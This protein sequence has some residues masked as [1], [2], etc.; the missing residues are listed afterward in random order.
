MYNCTLL[1][2]L[3]H[4]NLTF[5]KIHICHVYYS[6]LHKVTYCHLLGDTYLHAGFL[7]RE[8]STVDWHRNRY[9]GRG[10]RWGQGVY[11][12]RR[13]EFGGQT[14]SVRLQAAVIFAHVRAHLAVL[15]P[16]LV[17][18]SRGYLLTAPDTMIFILG[19]D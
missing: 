14:P 19:G 9:L 4:T 3:Y 15:F 16:T 6:S 5:T 7:L 17:G 12:W 10:W 8:G 18:A 13:R 11:R 2:L 1:F